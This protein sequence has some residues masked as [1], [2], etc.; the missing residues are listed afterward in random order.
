MRNRTPSLAPDEQNDVT[1]Y[2]V[3]NDC[4]ELGRAYVE[5]DE[6][7]A[8][9]ETVL[10]NIDSGEYSNPI[11]VVA[12]NT[13][14]EWSRDVTEDIERELLDREAKKGDLGESARKFVEIAP[15]RDALLIVGDRLRAF[16]YRK[17][18]SPITAPNAT[19]MA[20][21]P[22]RIRR[23]SALMTNV[24]VLLDV[25]ASRLGPSDDRFIAAL[26]IPRRSC[27]L[28]VP[29]MRACWAISKAEFN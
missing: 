29:E 28:V 26:R 13:A 17:W 27:S 12:F 25:E 19:L 24:L 14:E 1:V 4:G 6:A 16:Y 11:Q 9:K 7:K 5:T 22:I 18:L 3:L 20:T 23:V 2:I 15:Y 21:R 10:N 8:D